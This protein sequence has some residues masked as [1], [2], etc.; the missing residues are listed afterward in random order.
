MRDI[1]K[2]LRFT[3]LLTST[4]AVAYIHERSMEF[5]TFYTVIHVNSSCCVYSWETYRIFVTVYIV[6]HVNSSC[7]AY[8]REMYGICSGERLLASSKAWSQCRRSLLICND[9]YTM[10]L[11]N[12]PLERFLCPAIQAW[13][14]NTVRKVN[15]ETLRKIFQP[16]TCISWYK[17][18]VEEV[19]CSMSQLDTNT[20]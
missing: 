1:S 20:A 12:K 14:R 13:G 16:R 6:T 18:S 5:A 2:L 8:S 17:H 9:I 10:Y 7:C 15:I 3:L 4:P 19:C 11:V